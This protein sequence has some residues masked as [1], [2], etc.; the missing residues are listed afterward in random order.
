M[1]TDLRWSR[2]QVDT[3]SFCLVVLKLARPQCTQHSLV[4]V[5]SM[6]TSRRSGRHQGKNRGARTRRVSER[7]TVDV[8]DRGASQQFGVITSAFGKTS[9]ALLSLT[10]PH[11]NHLTGSKRALV[12]DC[13]RVP[14]CLLVVVSLVTIRR[15]CS[16]LG[17]ICCCFTETF[18]LALGWLVDV[19]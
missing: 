7:V 19:L 12:H 13:R 2:L 11:E 1:M 15:G 16:A 4:V 3:N 17:S 10:G 18:M 5:M 9:T 6:N 8:W 14:L